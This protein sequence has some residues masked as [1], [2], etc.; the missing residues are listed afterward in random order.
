M[1]Q[2]EACGHC[3]V[4]VLGLSSDAGGEG[5]EVPLGEDGRNVDNSSQNIKSSVKY[6]L[7]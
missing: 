4:V 3:V 6:R 5:V 7:V 2:L 1:T